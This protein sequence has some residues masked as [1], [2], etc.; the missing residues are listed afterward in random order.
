MLS[1]FTM[2]GTFFVRLTNVHVKSFTIDHSMSCPT[3]GFS[4]SRHNEV[5]DPFA[6]MLI[7][8]SLP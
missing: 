3:G 5:R 8:Q 4:T 7:N 1:A 2:G 6:A